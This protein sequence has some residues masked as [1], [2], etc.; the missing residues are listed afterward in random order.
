MKEKWRKN[1]RKKEEKM[2]GRRRTG[3]TKLGPALAIFIY[4]SKS[5]A[6]LYNS[7]AIMPSIGLP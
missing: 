1:E 5:S 6:S 4:R 3:R 2:K 7:H